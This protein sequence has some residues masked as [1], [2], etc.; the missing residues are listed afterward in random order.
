M[1]TTQ[2]DKAKKLLQK[3]KNYAAIQAILSNQNAWNDLEANHNSIRNH[4]FEVAATELQYGKSFYSDELYEDIFAIMI[5]FAKR[6]PRND[7]DDTGVALSPIS[8]GV[9]EK[10]ICTAKGYIYDA[11]EVEAILTKGQNPIDRTP[12]LVQDIK[13]L[14][15]KLH[16]INPEVDND[17]AIHIKNQQAIV[18][19]RLLYTKLDEM[20]NTF[21]LSSLILLVA[22][23][24]II[25]P[26]AVLV[27]PFAVLGVFFI[28]FITGPASYLKVSTKYK[29]KKLPSNT[30][31][32]KNAESLFTPADKE[33]DISNVSSTAMMRDT[34]QINVA[35]DSEPAVNDTMMVAS[36]ESKLEHE[37]DEPANLSNIVRKFAMS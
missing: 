28:P 17:Y 30:E 24:A 12:L 15:A 36:A 7:M 9:M 33:N 2:F 14:R 31:V 21:A 29:E 5:Y 1:P 37:N 35:P 13:Y 19:E 8:T 22:I 6:W 25:I 18:T 10:P 23:M 32:I 20:V 11:C 3:Y 26:V 34:L 16:K 27:S 4:L